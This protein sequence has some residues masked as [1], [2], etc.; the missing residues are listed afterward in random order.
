MIDIIQAET[1]RQPRM[2]NGTSICDW[3]LALQFEPD[4]P[5]RPAERAI[6]LETIRPARGE[7]GQRIYTGTTLCQ[8]IQKDI[9]SGAYECGICYEAVNDRTEIWLCEICWGVYHYDCILGCASGVQLVAGEAPVVGLGDEWKCPLCRDE[10]ASPPLQRCCE[11]GLQR[12]ARKIISLYT[13]QNFRVLFS[14]G[15]TNKGWLAF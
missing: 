3:I 11:L 6:P 12:Y 8:Q 9:D 10:Y 5:S 14:R 7:T 1:F 13:S 2:A 15:N 4:W